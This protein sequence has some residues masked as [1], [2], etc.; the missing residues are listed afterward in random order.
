MQPGPILALHKADSG[1]QH[2]GHGLELHNADHCNLHM[3]P[4][5]RAVETG[6]EIVTYMEGV[7]GVFMQPVP[8]LTLD[9]VDSRQQHTDHGQAAKH[10]LVAH[11]LEGLNVQIC[12]EV[13]LECDLSSLHT[14]HQAHNVVLSPI[15]RAISLA[16][17]TWPSS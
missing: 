13:V 7:Q 10:A 4:T 14:L 6:L 11:N 16:K 8:L 17:Q 3:L 1:Q 5:Y 15:C 2:T 9:K 12:H